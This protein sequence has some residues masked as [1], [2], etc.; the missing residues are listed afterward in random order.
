MVF[1]CSQSFDDGPGNCLAYSASKGAISGMILPM[2]W[3]LAPFGINVSAI[4]PGPMDTPMTAP[5][6]I[7]MK[8][9]IKT[10]MP[11]RKI[12]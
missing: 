9:G 1:V 5:L 2:A 11:L 12:G 3:D 6:P 8:E 7:E 10:L 4:S